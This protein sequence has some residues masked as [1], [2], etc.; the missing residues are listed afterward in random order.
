M[1]HES[2]Q[3]EVGDISSDV[4][5]EVDRSL[6]CP[7]EEVE[8]SPSPVA[9]RFYTPQP[10]RSAYSAA[11][12]S[13]AGIGPP[14]RFE[15]VTSPLSEHLPTGIRIPPTPGRL[16]KPVRLVTP[17]REPESEPEPEH[18][19]APATPPPKTPPKTPRGLTPAQ[20]AQLATPLQL[21]SAPSESFRDSVPLPIE[22]PRRSSFLEALRS[23]KKNTVSFADGDS[24]PARSNSS[25]RQFGGVRNRMP[26][27]RVDRIEEVD[28]LPSTPTAVEDVARVLYPQTQ[29]NSSQ[30]ESQR[31][32]PQPIRRR[33]LTSP[34]A[35]IRDLLARKTP[36]TPTLGLEDMVREPK[37]S[38]TPSF[39]GMREMFRPP[40]PSPAL[41]G[42]REMFAEKTVPPTPAFDGVREMFAERAVPPTPHMALEDVFPEP[43]EVEA[44]VAE[45]ESEEEAEPEPKP[46]TRS[47][48]PTRSIPAR[49]TRAGSRTQEEPE[50]PQARPAPK[51]R[52]QA[53]SAPEPAAVPAPARN[54]RAKAAPKA[55][56]PAPTSP[57]TRSAPTRRVTRSQTAEPEEPETQSAPARSTS[58]P[59]P[60]AKPIRR[61]RRVLGEAEPAKEDPAPKPAPAKKRTTLRKEPEE[62]TKTVAK[63]K[64]VADKENSATPDPAPEP[65]RKTALPVR[66]TRSRKN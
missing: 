22:T 51:T 33:S 20:R 9:A 66:V 28:S 58:K 39:A 36:K 15:D 21:P 52:R 16:G 14:L 50:E 42:V 64:G 25:S 47:R 34:I 44:E 8:R 41:G 31:S 3:E 55:A 2:H 4:D 46:R 13:L 54:T 49:T 53:K 29:P 57:E 26:T 60:E 63:G 59:E 5:D 35:G 56:I 37:V 61:S 40:A 18:E 32:T 48:V 30:P 27:P 45:E 62:K 10:K 7:P 19:E 6:V 23:A 38:K 12:L 1:S 17:A 43:E 65:K 24:T 11:R